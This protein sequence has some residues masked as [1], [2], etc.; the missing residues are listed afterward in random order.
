MWLY[1]AYKVFLGRKMY[2]E[3][4]R[5]KK[6][7]MSRYPNSYEAVDVRWDEGWRLYRNG[8]FLEAG[9]LL[10]D[11]VANVRE[12]W[13]R[14]RA[15]YW[16]A[17]ALAEGGEKERA[18]I[19]YALL[20]GEAPLGYYARLARADLDG[21][22]P[23]AFRDARTFKDGAVVAPAEKKR[24]PADEAVFALPA[25]YLRLGYPEAAIAE[26]D[27][28]GR[29]GKASGWLRYW[30]ED[31]H[32]AVEDASCAWNDWPGDT[33][34]GVGDACLLSFNPAF[35]ASVAAAA[36]ATGVHQHLL[37]AIAR[38][39]SHFDED[40][41]SLW[42]ARGLMQFIPPTA[43]R[44]AGELGLEEFSQDD[45]FKPET[46]LL[47]GGRYLRNLLDRFDG[48]LVSAIASYN[49]GEAAVSKWRKAR[50]GVD[51]AVFVELI[52]YRETRRYVKKVF[53][54]LDAYGRMDPEGLLK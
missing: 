23:F 47:L 53:T 4:S 38:T 54:A 19:V 31:F 49:G 51:E 50:A 17:R 3:S 29:R 11:S 27:R 30:S 41:Y 45:L 42:E 16:G 28:I 21:G 14:A 2:D 1:Q 43:L 46:A 44:I 9:K 5:A 7:L 26:L 48:N 39:E 13:Q 22:D 15:L 34:G 8:E 40:A 33:E 37:L 12:G 20:L 18:G 32:G 36:R 25:T 6:K 24:V 52:P 10:T 35:P